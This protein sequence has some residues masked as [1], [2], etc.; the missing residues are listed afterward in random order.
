MIQWEAIR[1]AKLENLSTY[2]FVGS[3]LPW[4]AKFKMSF[5]GRLLEYVY[6]EKSSSDWVEYLTKKVFPRY[7]RIIEIVRSI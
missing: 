7:K 3:D 5:G 6:L 4:L 1:K 2:D